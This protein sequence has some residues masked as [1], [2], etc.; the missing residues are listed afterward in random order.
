MYSPYS[1]VSLMATLPAPSSQSAAVRRFEL[2]FFNLFKPGRALAFPCD[3][4]GQVNMDD[5]TEQ[6]KVNYLA[7]RALVGRDYTRP[8]VV[9]SILH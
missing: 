1:L 8:V 9:A 3:A 4:S 7:A 6:A 5:L 2:R